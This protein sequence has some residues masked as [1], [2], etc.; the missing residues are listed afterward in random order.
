MDPGAI[1]AVQMAFNPKVA[2]F[3]QGIL[4]L[5]MFGVALE[6]RP[7]DF[8][9]IAKAP[10]PVI[11]GLAAQFFLLPAATFL[12][13]IA[14]PIPAS[15]KLGMIMVAA[16][17]GGNMSNFITHMAKGNTALSVSIT[18]VATL[19][20]TI[21]TPLNLTFWGGMR[22]DTAA[23]ITEFN[24]NPLQMLLAVF[25]IMGV[26]LVLGMSMGTRFP[27]ATSKSLVF[28]KYG[29][30]AALI[31]FIVIAFAANWEPFLNYGFLIMS[32]VILHNAAAL[33]IGYLTGW[34]SGL[35]KA[36][37]RAVT[38][39]VGIQNSGLGLA[40]IFT[41]FAGLGGMALVAGFWG[42][43]HII[44]GLTIARIWSR[45]PTESLAEAGEAA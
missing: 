1:D 43:W 8:A 17:P 21:M 11:M 10:K 4:A 20:A 7:R 27:Y 18:A 19:A 28:F 42:S 30:V 12:L 32:V 9:A 29:S 37:I 36:D 2:Y 44:A 26:P 16:C 24:M 23:L 22:A 33:S 35:P 5:V 34:L 13:T 41:F 14:L 31:I 25:V 39:E 38:I 6:L 3:L 40:L 45:R 15:M